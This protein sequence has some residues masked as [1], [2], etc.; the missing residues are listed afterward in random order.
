MVRHVTS[1][2][3]CP[4]RK[5]MVDI[6]VWPMLQNSLARHEG[7]DS[8]MPPPTKDWIHRE[9]MESPFTLLEESYEDLIGGCLNEKY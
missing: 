2:I 5:E 3:N 9:L 4:S 7:R 1:L 8:F 6:I